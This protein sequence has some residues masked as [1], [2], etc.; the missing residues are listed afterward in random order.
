[1][2]EDFAAQK[3]YLKTA[4]KRERAELDSQQKFDNILNTFLPVEKEGDEELNDHIRQQTEQDHFKQNQEMQERHYLEMKD[5]EQ[6]E[7]RARLQLPAPQV[8]NKDAFGPPPTISG[9]FPGMDSSV[10]SSISSGEDTE[11]DVE[12]PET[13]E[14]RKR[15][16]ALQGN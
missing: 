9:E 12:D 8:E 3:D 16:A 13:A 2:E 11:D 7:E 6:R 1:M 10:R 5:L 15:L 4:H 14:L